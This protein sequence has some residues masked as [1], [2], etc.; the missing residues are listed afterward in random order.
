[1]IIADPEGK[2]WEFACS[3]YNNLNSRDKKYYLSKFQVKR[4]RDNEIK[5]KI[6]DN[7]RR[8]NCFFIH[9][10]SLHPSEWLTQLI[11]A[12]EVM[13]NSSA[14]EIID[15]LPYMKFSRQD[16]KDESRVSINSKAVADVISRYADRVLTLDAHFTQIQGFYSIPLDNLY[17]SKILLQHLREK[18][19]D[20][21]EN[22][23]VMSPDT[24]GTSRAKAF[25]NTLGIE[26]IVI[27]YKYRPKAGEIGEF[28]IIGNDCL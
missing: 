23:V 10:S 11:F 3:I 19:P 26:D 15:V 7:I 4:F 1:M 16:R 27:G 2:A 18:H 5:V 21:L 25:A 8:K 17:S 9:D 20:S 24:G 14:D 6:K 28:R 13:K 12:N 22:I